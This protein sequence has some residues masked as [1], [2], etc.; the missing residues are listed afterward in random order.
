MNNLEFIYELMEKNVERAKD[1]DLLITKMMSME[2]VGLH[3]FKRRLE[4]TILTLHTNLS[5]YMAS[6]KKLI[7]YG[8]MNENQAYKATVELFGQIRNIDERLLR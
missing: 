3:V 5:L 2:S 4:W 6:I 1:L 7:K 8:D